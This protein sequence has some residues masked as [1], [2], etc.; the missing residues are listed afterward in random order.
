[1]HYCV[2]LVTFYNYFIERCKE[3]KQRLESM[4]IS[5][6]NEAMFYVEV[7]AFINLPEFKKIANEY[8][9]HELSV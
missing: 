8:Y 9:Q 1:M 3:E 6:I 5:N 2:A 7:S 4:G